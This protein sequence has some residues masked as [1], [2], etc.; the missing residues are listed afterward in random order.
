MKNTFLSY[1]K[2]LPVLFMLLC[3]MILQGRAS[4]S[5]TLYY[6]IMHKDKVIGS[7]LIESERLPEND[8]ILYREKVYLPYEFLPCRKEREA[9]YSP[10]E[11][12]IISFSEKVY[13][14][15]LKETIHFEKRKNHY[16]RRMDFARI[17]YLD[18]EI[19]YPDNTALICSGSPLLFNLLFQDFVKPV[20]KKSLISCLNPLLDVD[21]HFAILERLDHE[22]TFEGGF[23]AHI[24]A[25]GA[26]ITRLHFFTENHTYIPADKFP[27]FHPFIETK[28][29][30][31]TAPSPPIS[32]NNLNF[33]EVSCTAIDGSL[34]R[35]TLV[36]PR[37]AAP[38]PV[39]IFISGTG[40]F[41]R[42]GGG[43]FSSLSEA[44][45]KKGIASLQFDK[46]GVNASD[47]S[48]QTASFQQFVL[49]ADAWVNYLASRDDIDPLRIGVLGHSEGALTAL[50]TALNN[51]HIR[52]L[53]MMASPSVKMFP[54]MARE[55]SISF[56]AANSKAKRTAQNLTKNIETLK[57]ALDMNR[58]WYHYDGGR[59]Y[60]GVADSYYRMTDPLT[61]VQQTRIPILFL[62]GE[63]DATVDVSHS[64]QMFTTARESKND[65]LRMILFSETGHFFG[66]IIPESE[67]YPYRKHIQIQP[68]V[69]EA[70]TLW[71]D[72]F[73]IKGIEN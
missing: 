39:I 44:L 25:E 15:G 64:K 32:G 37:G 7:S 35:G 59:F 2:I 38:Y 66:S 8:F 57:K 34:Q 30:L 11:K 51:R 1:R 62:H 20:G 3:I 56:G 73:F 10:Q 47:G 50:E 70:I 61:A 17:F 58:L 23:N 4:A 31:L 22:Y 49:D 13:Y 41:D 42:R 9:V 54:D 33:L 18:E 28:G 14:D 63:A 55:Q 45:A 19:D 72:R 21:N 40:P 60:L 16:R 29:E 71:L 27:Q 67:A 69:L 36:L 24:T 6:T 5:S 53:I 68:Q 43:L 12:R 65:M 48:Y 46:R 52:G 26:K